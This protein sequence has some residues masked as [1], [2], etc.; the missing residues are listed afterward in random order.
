MRDLTGLEREFGGC[1]GIWCSGSEDIPGTPAHY[2]WGYNHMTTVSGLSTA[3]DGVGASG[4]KFSS[5]CAP[6]K[7]IIA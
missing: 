3:G 2:H 7:T 1:A 4:H 6:G 5:G